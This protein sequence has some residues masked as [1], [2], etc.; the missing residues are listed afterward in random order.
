MSRA[1]LA[2]FSISRADTSAA[3]LRAA[4]RDTSHISGYPKFPFIPIDIGTRKT[5]DYPRAFCEMPINSFI[6][7][8]G[9]FY[10]RFKIYVKIT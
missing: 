10:S 3:M 1:T 5:S 8:L 4:R 7:N 2:P 9:K 6:Y